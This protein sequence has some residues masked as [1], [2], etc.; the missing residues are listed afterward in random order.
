MKRIAA[1]A[2]F[3][4][5]LFLKPRVSEAFFKTYSRLISSDVTEEE[6]A[7]YPELP[8]DLF[9]DQPGL[10]ARYQ[11]IYDLCGGDPVALNAVQLYLLAQMEERT[12]DLLREGMG[13]S[14]GLTIE[15]AGKSTTPKRA[16][17]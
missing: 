11:R 14:E 2:A 9:E 6:L 15:T 10:A 17:K 8:E 5:S 1:L 7:G 16:L 4:L 3:K 12:Q 13:V